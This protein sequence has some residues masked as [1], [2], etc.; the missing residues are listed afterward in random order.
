VKNALGAASAIK[1]WWGGTITAAALGINVSTWTGT[2]T[3]IATFA[4]A[5]GLPVGTPQ[6]IVA[7]GSTPTAVTTNNAY[8]FRALSTTTGAFYNTLADAKADTNRLT[9]GTATGWSM[10]TVT[11]TNV[12]QSGFDANVPI[13]AW[14]GHATIFPELNLTAPLASL[15]A[16]VLLGNMSLPRSSDGTVV[17]SW[18]SSAAPVVISTTLLQYQAN[19]GN[20]PLA[21]PS[22]GGQPNTQVGSWAQLAN[23]SMV[24]NFV[25]IG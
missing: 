23:G 19:W 5:H 20:A 17:N 14:G 25:V 18:W 15:N 1:A 11:F 9:G 12:V 22:G 3:N 16:I 4:S 24:M 8:Y 10:R 2:T 21:V 7:T 6:L 13:G